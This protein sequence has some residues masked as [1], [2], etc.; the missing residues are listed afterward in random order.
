MNHSLQKIS[1]SERGSA[2]L[3]ALC[4]CAVLGIALASYMSV[5]Y[6]TLQ[7]SSRNNQG[8]HSFE[9]AETGMEEALEML[10]RSS[11]NWSDWTLNTSATPKS[12]TKTLSGFS[13]GN[14]TTGSVVVTVE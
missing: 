7:T 5:C 9:L 8:T 14:G 3:A 4:F 12:A 13:F 2:L 11:A 1:G 10:N 6:Q